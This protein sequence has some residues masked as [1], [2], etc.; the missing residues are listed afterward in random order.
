MVNNIST[1][2]ESKK[3]DDIFDI[4]EKSETTAMPESAPEVRERPVEVE[5]TKETAP[6][7]APETSP[8][9]EIEDESAQRKVALPPQ[10][11]QKVEVPPTTKSETLVQIETILSEHLDDLFMNMS[12]QEQ[13]MFKQK[14][15]ETA[16]KVELLMREVKIK[17][18]EVLNLIKNWLKIIPGVNKF[19]LEQEAKIKTD[20]I[21]AIREKQNKQ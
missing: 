8:E 6:E 7:I 17:V 13:I 10:S 16:T 14:G 9:K 1:E 19:F 5:A 18:K 21:L 4:A 12:P 11:P 3:V 15:E 20:R 2:K